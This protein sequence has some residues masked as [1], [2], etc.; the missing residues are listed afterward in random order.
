MDTVKTEAEI[1]QTMTIDGQSVSITHE[2][3]NGKI[4]GDI[5]ITYIDDIDA[6]EN[7]RVA[8]YIRIPAEFAPFIVRNLDHF[9]A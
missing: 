2:S 3:I 1:T 7:D 6:T 9:N 8:K 5:Q 4:R